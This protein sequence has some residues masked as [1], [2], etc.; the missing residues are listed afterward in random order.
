M[1][2]GV[3][4]GEVLGSHREPVWFHDLAA[5]FLCKRERSPSM[6]R[7]VSVS[8][9]PKM[10]QKYSQLAGDRCYGP[11]LGIFSAARGQHYSSTFQIAVRPEAAKQI[12]CL[13]DQQAS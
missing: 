5:L 12:L 8:C 4:T 9:Y 6:R 10:V 3:L 2:N 1:E 7:L 13:L 11:L